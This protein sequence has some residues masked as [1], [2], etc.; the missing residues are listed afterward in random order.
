MDGYLQKTGVLG[1][2]NGKKRQPRNAGNIAQPKAGSQ[3]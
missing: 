1:T 3:Y 2:G